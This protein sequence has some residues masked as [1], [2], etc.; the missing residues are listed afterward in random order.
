MTRHGAWQ[1]GASGKEGM[2]WNS[3]LYFL[4]VTW[5]HWCMCLG[6]PCTPV[7]AVVQTQLFNA[8]QCFLMAA[9]HWGMSGGTSHGMAGHVALSHGPM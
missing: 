3:Q 7:V 2:G 1:Q 6:Q 9:N 5:K 8:G 4:Y